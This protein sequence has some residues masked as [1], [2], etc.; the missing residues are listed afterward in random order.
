MQVSSNLSFRIALRRHAGHCSTDFT[1]PLHLASSK[2][3]AQIAKLGYS[4]YMVEGR[5][6]Q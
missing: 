3:L 6:I 4:Y 2:L 5:E 1:A